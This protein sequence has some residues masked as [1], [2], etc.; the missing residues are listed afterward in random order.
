MTEPSARLV[1]VASTSVSAA[2]GAGRTLDALLD[3]PRA[4]LGTLIGVS[5]IGF[6][7]NGGIAAAALVQLVLAPFFFL[8]LCVLYYEQRARAAV[9]SRGGERE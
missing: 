6:A 8:G 9:S 1:S 5:L 4:V 2:R 3:R 7:D